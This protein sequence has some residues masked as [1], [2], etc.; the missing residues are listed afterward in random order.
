MAEILI[1]DLQFGPHF[2]GSAID[3][4]AGTSRKTIWKN[5][6]P[7]SLFLVNG[8]LQAG[9]YYDPSDLSSMFQDVAETVPAAVNGPVA[10][11]N[12]KSGNGNHLLQATAANQPILKSSGSG[13]ATL[14]WLEFDGANDV[15]NKVLGA[16]LPQP[17]SRIGAIRIITWTANLYV[18]SGANDIIGGLI[19]TGA[20]PNFGM[21]DGL[22]VSPICTTLPINTDGVI[23]EVFNNASSTITLNN[24]APVTGNPGAL[25]IS[26]ITV[27]GLSPPGTNN[28]NIRWYGLTIRA[29]LFAVTETAALRQLYGQ[30]SGVAV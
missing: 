27:G 28:S 20:S 26:N 9:A 15:L 16:S 10:R 11:I 8:V 19:E 21:V 1:P 30:K 24:D 2:A 23:S 3:P 4:I 29:G 18:Y 22:A 13:P 6:N 17:F 25:N 5:I 7:A 14:Y 12:D